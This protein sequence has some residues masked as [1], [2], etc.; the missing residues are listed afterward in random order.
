LE[1]ERL[2]GRIFSKGFCMVLFQGTGRSDFHR[3]K[4][5]LPVIARLTRL[6]LQQY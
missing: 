3:R 5:M 1:Q 2:T 4:F 6:R